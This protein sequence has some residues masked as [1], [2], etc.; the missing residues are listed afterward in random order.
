[1]PP[2]Q[3]SLTL[4]DDLHA[5]LLTRGEPIHYMGAARKLLALAEAPARIC[6]E[7]IETL[8]AEDG[9]FCWHSPESL[10][11]TDWA[12]HDPDFENSSFVVVDVETTGGRPGPAKMTEIAVVRVEK[13]A[14]VDEFHTLVNPQRPIPPKIIEITGITPDMVRNAP[15]IEEVLPFVLDFIGDAIFV[16]HNVRFDLSFLN[17]ELSRLYGRRLKDQAIDT[18]RMARLL[19]PGLPNHRLA[20]VATALGAPVDQYH[21]ALPDARATAHVLLT[22]LGRLQE[23][24]VTRLSQVQTF[25]D[26]EHRRHRHKIALT[27][28]IPRTPGT[29]LFRDENNNILYVGKAERLRD[30]VRSYF[31]SGPGHSR[32]I[33]QAISRLERIEWVETATPLE[34]VVQEQMLIQQHRPPYN[35]MGADSERYVYL[36]AQGKNGLRLYVSRTAAARANE[37]VIGPFRSKSKLTAAV[38]L[39]QHLYPIRRCVR[40]S[41]QAC[42]YRQTGSCLAPCVQNIRVARQHDR[43][44]RALVMW[45]AGHDITDSNIASPDTAARLELQRLASQ[46]RFEEAARLRS[47]LEQAL[48]LRRAGLAVRQ[49]LSTC[50]AIVWPGFRSSGTPEV[51]VDIV[52]EGR[53]TE[54]V[55]CTVNTAWLNISRAVRS[56]PKPAPLGDLFALEKKDLDPLLAIRRWLNENPEAARVPFGPLQTDHLEALE[57]WCRQVVRVALQI[58]AAK[59][60]PVWDPERQDPW[61]SSPRQAGSDRSFPCRSVYPLVDRTG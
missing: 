16:G 59:Q 41:P 61:P 14:V 46:L 36:K 19:V 32:R 52:W 54:T 4:A 8:V 34:A 33:R 49:A 55:T 45:L 10:G 57:S 48:A 50:A 6:R 56:L 15:R 38:E 39:F 2:F 53:L 28:G 20:T 30:R 43:M 22:L 3:L 13:L 60:Q 31:V 23:Q 7:V 12:A 35:T 11:L 29:Y 40:P 51:H 26:P 58:L 21:R 17:Y 44:V 9:R 42:L 24:G 18:L 1:M 5:L 27:E 37:Y 47:C 25:A